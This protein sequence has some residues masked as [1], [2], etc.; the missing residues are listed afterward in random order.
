MAEF[1]VIASWAAFEWL[2]VFKTFADL[3]PCRLDITVRSRVQLDPG[4][5]HTIKPLPVCRA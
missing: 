1:N 4:P 2:D 3:A 5:G